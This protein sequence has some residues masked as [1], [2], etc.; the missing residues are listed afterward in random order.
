M[1]NEIKV[2]QGIPTP[3]IRIVLTNSQTRQRIIPPICKKLNQKLYLPCQ[4]NQV[5]II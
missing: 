5:Q 3:Y 1:K 4:Q 2:V